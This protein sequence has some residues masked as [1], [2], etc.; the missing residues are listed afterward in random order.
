MNIIGTER[1]LSDD[2]LIV[3]KT[4]KKGII[5]YAND[6]F[7]SIAGYELSEVLGKP[8]NMVRHPLMPGCVF[9][10][11]WNTIQAQEG[12]FAYVVNKGKGDIY[13]WVLAYVTPSFDENNQ[14]VGYH[15]TRRKPTERALSKIKPLYKALLD[16]ESK[17]STRREGI[18]LSSQKLTNILNQEGK[19]YEEYILSL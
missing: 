16:E 17:A 9:K 10:L 12:I 8:H 3:S 4:D 5:T 2:G 6:Y 15:S 13:Y 14:L 7:C 1:V 19:N 11:L 18:E